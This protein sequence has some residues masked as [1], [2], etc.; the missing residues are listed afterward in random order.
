M[1]KEKVAVIG[2]GISGL[3]ASLFLSKKYEVHLF[4]KNDYLG[5]HTR[6]KT[7]K[8]QNQIY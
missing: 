3:S 5:G 6:T 8:E 4:E 2:A 7:I 1:N